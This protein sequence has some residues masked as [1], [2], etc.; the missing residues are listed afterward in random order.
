VTK[1][2]PIGDY[3]VASR[4]GAVRLSF[5]EIERILGFPLPASARK[6]NAWWANESS[7]THSHASA[8]LDRGYKTRELDL[9]AQSVGF[10]RG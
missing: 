1:Y 3:L 4:E 2:A 7:G 8:W 10:V 5:P 6:H 9:N